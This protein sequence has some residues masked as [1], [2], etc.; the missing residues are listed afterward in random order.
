[1]GMRFWVR[2]F[3][4]VFAGAFLVIGLAQMLRGHAPAYAAGQGLLWGA[5]SAALFTATR[6]YRSRQGQHCALCADTPEM[7]NEHPSKLT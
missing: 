2:R 4:T 3:L 7:Q 5:L 6:I 1:M